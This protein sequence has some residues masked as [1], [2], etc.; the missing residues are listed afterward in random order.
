MSLLGSILFKATSTD[1]LQRLGAVGVVLVTAGLS[2]SALSVKLH[3]NKVIF[4]EAPGYSVNGSRHLVTRVTT[5]TSAIAAA[6]FLFYF[7]IITVS[8]AKL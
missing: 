2:T 4:A 8:D 1:V 6:F 7:F 5:F 3:A